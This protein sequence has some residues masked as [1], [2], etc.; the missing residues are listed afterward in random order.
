M[1]HDTMARALIAL[2]AVAGAALCS[3]AAAAE[4][5]I[6]LEVR[7]F[8][9][10]NLGHALAYS[11]VTS[12]GAAGER[13]SVLA[14]VSPRDYYQLVATATTEA[15]GFWR[16]ETVPALPTAT[17]RARWKGRYSD[18]VKLWSPID[19]RRAVRRAS[20]PEVHN[21]AVKV[22]LDTTDTQQNLSRKIVELQRY[23]QASGRWLRYG[24]ANL[25]RSVR[26]AFTFSATFHT[27]PRGLLLRVF[28]P[29]KT[30]APCY[31]P[32]LSQTFSS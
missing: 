22:F 20:A 27:L 13:V 32:Q 15:G 5:P 23:E 30:A 29:K 17:F 8:V 9:D 10:E 7:T 3:W 2:A 14:K 12:S 24:R 25:R 4:A 18:A 16:D 6:T 19:L 31:L 11:G 21:G 28:V 26:A 1:G